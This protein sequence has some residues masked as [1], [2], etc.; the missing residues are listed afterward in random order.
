MA[1]SATKLERSALWLWEAVVAISAGK[2]ASSTA[3]I[4]FGLD[5]VIEVTSAT[6]V[7]CFALAAC[8]TVESLRA[9]LGG[10]SAEHST[11]GIVL[12]AISLV[13]MPAATA[14]RS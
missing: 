7:A 4:G 10:E 12:A 2:V 3:L 6:A 9:L 13:V 14:R 8:I 5:S 1:R 11:V